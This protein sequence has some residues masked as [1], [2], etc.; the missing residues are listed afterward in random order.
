MVAGSKGRFLEI[1]AGSIECSKGLRLYP[2]KNIVLGPVFHER[3]AVP[4][5]VGKF[6]ESGN[7]GIV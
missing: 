7:D 2:V 4:W 5:A 3:I 6:N 1:I